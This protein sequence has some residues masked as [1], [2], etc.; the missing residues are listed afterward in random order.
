MRDQENR[1]K[2]V[3][4]A[5]CVFKISQRACCLLY[6]HAVIHIGT[7]QNVKGSVCMW[8]MMLL[9]GSS[10]QACSERHE[11]PVS[12]TMIF[13]GI[14]TALSQATQ[15]VSIPTQRRAIQSPLRPGCL[16]PSD[17]PGKSQNSYPFGSDCSRRGLI[18]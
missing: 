9:S 17:G 8:G 7:G 5:L 15:N 4:F 18:K 11:N 10:W 2:T 14:K 6:R 13:R 16:I 3:H 12:K 1:I